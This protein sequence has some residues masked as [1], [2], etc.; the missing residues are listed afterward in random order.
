[1]KKNSKTSSE[2]EPNRPG[3]YWICD[4]CAAKQN[5]V[6]KYPTG[7]NTVMSGYCSHC[8]RTDEATLIPVCD[9]KRKGDK[10]RP[11]WAEWD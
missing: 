4:D 6:T 1:M 10:R 3:K 5:L 2:P 7:G 8:E 9:F 11:H